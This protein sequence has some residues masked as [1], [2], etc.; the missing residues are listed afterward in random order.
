M[1]NNAEGQNYRRV[2]EEA[3][4]ETLRRERPAARDIADLLH[5]TD[6]QLLPP[7]GVEMDPLT[8][9]VIDTSTGETL[10]T[11]QETKEG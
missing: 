6:E 2:V 7:I 1:R 11:I 3:A 8:N 5:R 4:G 10:G 9:E